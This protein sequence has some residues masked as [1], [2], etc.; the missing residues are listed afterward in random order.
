MVRLH[1]S[2]VGFACGFSL[3]VTTTVW[4]APIQEVWHTPNGSSYRLLGIL[5][6]LNHDRVLDMVTREAP[7]QPQGPIAVRSATT[8]LIEG[9][10]ASPTRPDYVLN[11]DLDGDGLEELV[12]YDSFS[13]R[14]VCLDFTGSTLTQRWSMS[15]FPTFN[16]WFADLDGNGHQYMVFENTS[17]PEVQFA[18][19]DRNAALVGNYSPLAPRFWV[20]DFVVVNDVDSDGRDEVLFGFRENSGSTQAQWLSLLESTAVA[21]VE[22]Q[23]TD[24]KLVALG[25]G[26]PNPAGTKTHISYSMPYRGFAMLRMVDVSGRA[27]RTLVDGDVGAGTHEATWDGRDDRGRSLPAGMYWYELN[28]NG[29]R[30]ARSMVRLP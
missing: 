14:L 18:V 25:S 19:Y 17:V 8:G 12:Y 11:V 3:I 1:A 4:A 5:T 21:G 13:L 29:T 6:D 22:S 30:L 26:Y 10:T 7:D 15:P 16:F 24:L 2:F 9:Q 23:A 27:V 20:R 28:A